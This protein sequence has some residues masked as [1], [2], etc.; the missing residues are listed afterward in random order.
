MRDDLRGEERGGEEGRDFFLLHLF[1][2]KE[3][4]DG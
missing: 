2:M 4:M 3:W 1:G